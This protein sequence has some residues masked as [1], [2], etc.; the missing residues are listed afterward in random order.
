LFMRRG[1]EA[2]A[3]IVSMT[4]HGVC[5]GRSLYSRG[6]RPGEDDGDVRDV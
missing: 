1:G 6:F 3:R 5:G 4:I 2:G